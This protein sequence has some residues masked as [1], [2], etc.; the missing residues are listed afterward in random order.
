MNWKR[1][2]PTSSVARNE[3]ITS[4]ATRVY[5][6]LG[7]GLLITAGVTFAIHYLGL[8][9]PLA[10]YVLIWCFALMG[11]AYTMQSRAHTLSF[12]GM[13]AL[14]TAYA[15]IE[16]LFFGTIIPLYIAQAGIQTVWLAFAAAAVTC[17][18]AISYGAFTKADLTAV[19][20]LLNIGLFALIAISILCLVLQLFM[21]INGIQLLIAYAGLL[22]FVGLAATD[23]QQIQEVSRRLQLDNSESASKLSLLVALKMYAN[24]VMV[25]LYMLQILGSSRDN[26]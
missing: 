2:F 15:V 20:S 23:A 7:L 1:E 6:W 26:R 8:D 11:I 3:A 19:R 16:G 9:R 4:F 14:F 5:S 12:E 18:T 25:F 10:P 21:P 17:A 24:V 22:L 13:A